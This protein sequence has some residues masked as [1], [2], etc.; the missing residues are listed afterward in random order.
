MISYVT[1]NR[2]W[3]S[4]L[5]NFLAAEA[6]QAIG[7]SPT[8]EQM[9]GIKEEATII[10]QTLRSK[11]VT[12]C[13]AMPK[14]RL[15]LSQP[16]GEDIHVAFEMTAPN[17]V[18]GKVVAVMSRPEQVL[19]TPYFR[20]VSIQPNI[21][22]NVPLPQ[23]H[24][25]LA[26]FYGA[27]HRLVPA[28]LQMSPIKIYSTDGRRSVRAYQVR[29]SFTVPYLFPDLSPP[30]HHTQV[31]LGGILGHP[32]QIELHKSD[33]AGLAQHLKRE[34]LEAPA[35]APQPVPNPQGQ[36]QPGGGGRTH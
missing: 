13:G 28:S 20:P 12:A 36:K 9:N 33:L 11:L 19:G 18:T 6:G 14:L 10:E 4:M 1:V 26:C 29:S 27:Q 30:F 3:E 16:H 35:P 21:D 8:P 2:R 17:G 32:A 34:A 24:P 22:V 15:A 25:Q 23:A 5:R 31:D 7:P